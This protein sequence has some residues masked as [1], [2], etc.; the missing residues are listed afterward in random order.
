MTKY[1][2]LLPG[3]P[4]EV[5]RRRCTVNT[6]TSLVPDRVGSDEGRQETREAMREEIGDERGERREATREER[7]EAQQER[8]E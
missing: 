5:V 6:T 7:V 3:A 1:L 4:S 2:F 8:R